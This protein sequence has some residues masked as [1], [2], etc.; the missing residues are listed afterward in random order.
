[1]LLLSWTSPGDPW[2]LL[3]GALL[4]VPSWV[5]TCPRRT[6]AGLCVR[7]YPHQPPWPHV[8]V[9]GATYAA[10]PPWCT[11]AIRVPAP[12]VPC[13]RKVQELASLPQLPVRKRAYRAHGVPRL[14]RYQAASPSRFA[15]PA[16][17]QRRWS[18]AWVKTYPA[19]P[20]SCTYAHDPAPCD[21]TYTTQPLATVRAPEGR[22]LPPFRRSF[23]THT[24]YAKGPRAY[25]THLRN[26][27]SLWASGIPRGAAHR[28]RSGRC[29]HLRL[30]PTT[31]RE[32][33][34]PCRVQ[35]VDTPCET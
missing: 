23:A 26:V 15:S 18:G 32:Q 10:G 19:G 24:Q 33:R 22:A 29:G 35:T 17:A 5:D 3:G 27:S 30:A 34:P 1:M 9:Q 12:G 31:P 28:I 25:R 14:P 6:A 21:R 4:A 8:G 7:D 11:C 2:G 20:P 13:V 16:A